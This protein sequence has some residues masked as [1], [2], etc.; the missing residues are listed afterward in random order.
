MINQESG[1]SQVHRRATNSPRTGGQ[2]TR[3]LPRVCQPYMYLLK[4]RVASGLPDTHDLSVRTSDYCLCN[5][6]TV[7][8]MGT[9]H[10][11]ARDKSS[12][13]GTRL[14]GLTSGSAVA[15]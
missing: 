15:P 3:L 13:P 7:S 6:M 2:L 5:G 11:A 12:S 4:Q 9:T 1:V 10:Q 14:P 8:G